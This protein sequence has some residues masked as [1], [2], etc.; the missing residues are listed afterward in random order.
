MRTGGGRR[1]GLFS[2][3]RVP[4]ARSIITW[5]IMHLVYPT[6]PKKKNIYIYC[7]TIVFNS[8]GYHREIEDKGCAKFGGGGRGRGVNRVHYGLCENSE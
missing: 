2:L 3:S 4:I 1:E 8:S 7:I 5:A 6:P